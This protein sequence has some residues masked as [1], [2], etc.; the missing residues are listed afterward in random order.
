MIPK[1]R[2]YFDRYERMIYSIGVVNENA[3]LVDFN[4]DGDLETIFLTNDINL[5][6]YSELK[7][8][9]KSEIYEHDVLKIQTYDLC[10]KKINDEY[11]GVVC[12]S[13]GGFFVLT[14]KYHRDFCLWG[15]GT[16]NMEVIGNIHEN[17]ELLDEVE[18]D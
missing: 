7:D 3:I 6:L 5:M 8:K 16:G 15:G 10:S 1:F 9:N 13:K 18:D 17:P 14:D 11:L 12:F 2:A 4:G